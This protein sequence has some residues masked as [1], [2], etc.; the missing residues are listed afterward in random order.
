[1]PQVLWPIPA[2]SHESDRDYVVFKGN[3]SCALCVYCSIYATVSVLFSLFPCSHF[4]YVNHTYLYQ[5]SVQ[6]RNPLVY[7]FHTQL[8]ATAFGKCDL[9]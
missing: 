4:V 7:R 3:E 9:T 6:D 1:M 2:P 8:E 5:P